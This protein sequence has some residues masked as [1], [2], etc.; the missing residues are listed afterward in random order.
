MVKNQGL[1][2]LIYFALDGTRELLAQLEPG[3]S[4]RTAVHIAIKI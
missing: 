1:A 3:E 2:Q 4:A